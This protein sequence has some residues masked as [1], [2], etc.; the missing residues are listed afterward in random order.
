M[1][2]RLAARVAVVST[3]VVLAL[4]SFLELA[5]LFTGVGVTIANTS[6]TNRYVSDRVEVLLGRRSKDT[7]S[8]VGVTCIAEYV[9]HIVRKHLH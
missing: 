2:K 8:R 1:H 4:T 3:R 7:L 9:I 6:A 5:V